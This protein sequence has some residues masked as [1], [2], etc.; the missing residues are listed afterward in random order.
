[1][2]DNIYTCVGGICVYSGFCDTSFMN[3]LEKVKKVKCSL[4]KVAS[5]CVGVHGLIVFDFNFI[6]SVS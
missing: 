2:V 1:M 5:S 4:W 3:I 6:K